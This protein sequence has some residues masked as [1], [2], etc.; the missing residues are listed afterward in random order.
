[1]T[2]APYS[3]NKTH[4]RDIAKSARLVSALH[5]EQLFD[6]VSDHPFDGVDRDI[7]NSNHV[8]N[9]LLTIMSEF[10][11]D[12]FAIWHDKLFIIGTLYGKLTLCEWTIKVDD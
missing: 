8:D 7:L 4:L 10:Q 1:M 5:Y 2:H 3:L 9:P 11:D 6:I 12:G